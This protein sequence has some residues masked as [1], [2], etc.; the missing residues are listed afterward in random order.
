M[1]KLAKYTVNQGPK[2]HPLQWTLNRS[3]S[4]IHG[5]ITHNLCFFL[6]RMHFR[7]PYRTRDI[8]ARGVY[9]YGRTR[10]ASTTQNARHFPFLPLPWSR[11][12]CWVCFRLLLLLL[13]QRYYSYM[14]RS[15]YGWNAIDRAEEK[16]RSPRSSMS[17]S[18]YIGT[19]T[20]IIPRYTRYK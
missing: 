4:Y 9:Y 17:D 1:L 18:Y 8:Y 14:R 5:K 3:F 13:P 2:L 20:R 12:C 7:L 19:Y 10:R 16:T 6:N 15:K 11:S